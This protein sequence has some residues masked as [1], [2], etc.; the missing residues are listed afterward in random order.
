MYESLRKQRD[1]RVTIN[2]RPLNCIRW[3][4]TKHQAWSATLCAIASGTVCLSLNWMYPKTLYAKIP[5]LNDGVGCEEAVPNTAIFYLLRRANRSATC[6]GDTPAILHMW[7]PKTDWLR[8]THIWLH[9]NAWFYACF[10]W[11]VWK[12]N[13]CIYV[14]P[15]SDLIETRWSGQN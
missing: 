4:W 3:D 9:L 13:T 7:W 8:R 5:K 15:P 6:T 1:K 10:P 2:A 11:L 12:P 14:F